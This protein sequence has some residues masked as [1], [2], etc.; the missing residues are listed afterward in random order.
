MLSSKLEKAMDE[1]Y[2]EC[3]SY[4]DWFLPN[5]I[6]EFAKNLLK[7]GDVRQESIVS[8]S[9]LNT[10]ESIEEAADMIIDNLFVN[11]SIVKPDPRF[12]DD[13]M[14]K[15]KCVQIG[16]Y[17]V[18]GLDFGRQRYTFTPDTITRI[19]R[20]VNDPMAITKKFTKATRDYING[21]PAPK[22]EIPQIKK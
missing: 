4:D 19:Q 5:E 11:S 2:E 22:K 1:R 14:E 17:Q 15:D 9:E 3:S 6:Y 8:R 20:G 12:P 21:T 16:A 18:G 13:I 7:N 10:Q